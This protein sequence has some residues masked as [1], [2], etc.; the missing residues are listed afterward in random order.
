MKH[1]RETTK[2]AAGL[3]AIR[4]ESRKTIAGAMDTLR[5]V[6]ATVKDANG[7]TLTSSGILHTSGKDNV[8]FD[9]S[10]ESA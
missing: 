1:A 7:G 8:C 3:S 5:F 2:G 9:L 4:E 6:D 10:A